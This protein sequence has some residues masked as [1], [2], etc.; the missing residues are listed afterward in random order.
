MKILATSDTHGNLS[1]IDLTGIDL[2]VFA[3]DV[4]LLDGR[5]TWNLYHQLKWMNNAFKTW[6]QKWPDT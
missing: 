6:C 4:A 3:G 2:A 5:G 1:G